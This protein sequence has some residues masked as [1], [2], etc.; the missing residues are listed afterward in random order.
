MSARIGLPLA[1][2]SGWNAAE[3]ICDRHRSRRQSHADIGFR[4]VCKVK[5][6]P[7]KG[8]ENQ[9]R[10]SVGFESKGVDKTVSSVQGDDRLPPHA[11]QKR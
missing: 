3:S 9:N 4:G 8:Y 11:P 6:T 10:H 5:F 1:Q 2:R 7:Q